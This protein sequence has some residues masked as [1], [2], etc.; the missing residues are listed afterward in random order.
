M[1]ELR[2]ITKYFGTNCAV[3]NV[4][5]SIEHGDLFALLGPNGAGKSTIL[6]MIT[7]LI[8]PSHGKIQINGNELISN[9]K[10][11]VRKMGVVFENPSFYLYLTGKE[12]LELLAK[13][14]G[15]PDKKMINKLLD[16]VSLTS[17]AKDLV[18]KYSLGMKQ[19]LA[20]AC[21]LIGNP[22]ILILDEPTNGLDPE[23][24]QDILTLL[25]NFSKQNQKTI[26][27]SSHQVYDI[28]SI[29]NK[30]AIINKGSM[31]CYGKLDELLC[32][33]AVSCLITTDN[34]NECKRILADKPWVKDFTLI[35]RKKNLRD[36][37]IERI[38]NN[39]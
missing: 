16:T 32:E 3:N 24:I 9:K 37:Y 19:R 11:L 22:D 20:L 34:L 6:G 35:N 8:E 7:G 5:L 27:I 17:R 38:K 12:N 29:C 4:D 30:I 15:Y 1:I 21:A 13:L 18:K 31:L 2:N 26:L 23:G 10:M 36:F 14:K 28:E 33:N 39:E 25:V